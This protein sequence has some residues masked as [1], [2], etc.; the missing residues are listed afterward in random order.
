MTK[1][2]SEPTEQFPLEGSQLDL[3]TADGQF[4]GGCTANCP[5]LGAAKL[6]QK[7]VSGSIAGLKQNSYW[8]LVSKKHRVSDIASAYAHASEQNP[9]WD[10]VWWIR[11]RETCVQFHAYLRK[12]NGADARHGDASAEL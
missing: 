8:L 3:K 2:G 1:V 12:A 7:G 4:H 11:S 10:T 9:S 5:Q 6:S